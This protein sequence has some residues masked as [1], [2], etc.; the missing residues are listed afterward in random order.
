[1]LGVEVFYK[2]L[3]LRSFDSAESIL[4]ILSTGF[5]SESFQVP[6][7]NLLADL[8]DSKVP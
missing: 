6:V 1:M 3:E 5:T 2:A 8:R 4:K 7:F